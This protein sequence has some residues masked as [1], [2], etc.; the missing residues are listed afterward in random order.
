[1][2]ATW[3]Y[4]VTSGLLCPTRNAKWL[5]FLAFSRRKIPITSLRTVKTERF[6]C[7]AISLLVSPL[8]IRKH[9]RRSLDFSVGGILRSA[10]A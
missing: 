2:Q 7:S 6:N 8:A 4:R 3:L 5:R 10:G 1:M 9:I